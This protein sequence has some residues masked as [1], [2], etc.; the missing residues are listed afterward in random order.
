[1]NIR[2]YKDKVHLKTG[3]TF[4]KD[5]FTSPFE[6][7]N[8]LHNKGIRI[9]LNVNPTEGFYDIDEYYEQAAKYLEKDENGVIPFNSLDPKCI[10]VYLKLFI[11]YFFNK[12]FT[13]F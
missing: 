6:M 9:G 11:Q 8:Y 3:F 13:F 5:L 12:K 1:M 7:I 4:N 2:T 10:D